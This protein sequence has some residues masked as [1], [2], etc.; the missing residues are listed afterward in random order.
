MNDSLYYLM[1]LVFRNKTA[2]VSESLIITYET[3]YHNSKDIKLNFHSCDNL[4][5]NHKH[6]IHL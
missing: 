4:K 1:H 5:S 2:D 6:S 3:K